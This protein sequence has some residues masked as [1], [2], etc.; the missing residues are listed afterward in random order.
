MRL[1]FATAKYS[2]RLEV[3]AL[4]DKLVKVNV[5][6]FLFSFFLGE[7]CNL[8]R[9]CGDIVRVK[10]KKK[11]QPYENVTRGNKIEEVSMF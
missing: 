4:W 3:N 11:G 2:L 7:S 6:F 5:F 9:N 10:K 8:D 1:R